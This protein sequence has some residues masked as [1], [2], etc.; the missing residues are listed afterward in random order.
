MTGSF[1]TGDAVRFLARAI[2]DNERYDVV[3]I[4]PPSVSSARGETWTTGRDYPAL[5]AQAAAVIPDGGVLWLAA[6]THELGS[7]GKLA[8]KGLR[9]R[10]AAI[11][12]QAGL[13]P[14]YPTVTAQPA[15]RYLQICVL[16]LA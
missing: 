16:R 1:E 3:L 2:R 5:I 6:N 7:L 4:D 13:P 12:E 9:G 11:V 8:H 15:D 10:P 14:E